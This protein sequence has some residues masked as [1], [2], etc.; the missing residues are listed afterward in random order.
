MSSLLLKRILI[1]VVAKNA[2]GNIR[3]IINYL[4]G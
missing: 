2:V 3:T 4:R 1:D